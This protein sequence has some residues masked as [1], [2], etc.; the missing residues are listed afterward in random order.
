MEAYQTTKR[1]LYI[2]SIS[3]TVLSAA[4]AGSVAIALLSKMW[5]MVEI[6]SLITAA[7]GIMAFARWKELIDLPND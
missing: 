1:R 4:A 3:W 6:Q 7:T 2:L 5:P